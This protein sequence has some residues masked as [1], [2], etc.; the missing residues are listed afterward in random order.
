VLGRVLDRPALLPVPALALR[1]AFGEM[2]DVAV[3]SSARVLPVRLQESGYHF[4]YP[5]LEGAL[6]YL[7]GQAARA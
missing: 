3:L 7:L 1:L 2:A 5:D 6:R 4:R